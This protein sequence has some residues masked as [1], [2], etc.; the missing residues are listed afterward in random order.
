MVRCRYLEIT[1]YVE[2][3]AGVQWNLFLLLCL[4]GYD[5]LVRQSPLEVDLLRNLTATIL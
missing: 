1:D 2:V 4:V 5:H 3:A